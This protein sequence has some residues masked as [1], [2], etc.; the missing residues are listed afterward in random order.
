[1]ETRRWSKAILYGLSSILMAALATSLLFSL[2]L[3]FTGL[4][5]D[6][7]KWFILGLSFLAVFIGGFIA[8]G[9]GK[10]R[11]WLIG[12]TTAILYTLII[13]LFQFLGYGKTFTMEQ[14]MY[15]G[16]YLAISML[17]GIMGVNLSGSSK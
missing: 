2:L 5:E 8:G 6:S 13:F 17:G 10:E 9:K 4:T 12:G 1:M 7:I 3:K 14:T 11:G 15:H 16:G